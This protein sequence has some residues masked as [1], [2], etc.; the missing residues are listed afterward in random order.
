MA[1][2]MWYVCAQFLCS[3]VLI[4]CVCLWLIGLGLN[5]SEVNCY[6]LSQLTQPHNTAAHNT[7]NSQHKACKLKMLQALSSFLSHFF[8]LSLSHPPTPISPHATDENDWK[9]IIILLI[10]PIAFYVCPMT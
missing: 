1:C 3:P 4:V 6:L 2:K 8:S 7:D 9:F 10:L 5:P